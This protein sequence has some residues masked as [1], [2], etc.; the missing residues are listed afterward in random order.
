MTIKVLRGR[1]V[2]R[3]ELLAAYAAFPHLVIPEYTVDNE[4]AVER[5]RKSHVGTVLAV[6][7]PPLLPSGAEMPLGFKVGDRVV[8][9]WE[10][11]EKNHTREW[12]D[13]KPAAWIPTY[14][15][16]GVVESCA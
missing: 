4:Q 13:G 9:H 11:Y 16:D 5:A 14:C 15:V 3:E 7:D 1:V 12:S 2:I 6:G 10:H 8:F